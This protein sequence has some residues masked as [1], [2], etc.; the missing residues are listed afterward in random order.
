MYQLLKAGGRLDSEFFP[1]SIG[2]RSFNSLA[3]YSEFLRKRDVDTV[4]VFTNYDTRWKTNEHELLDEL[5]AADQCNAGQ[6]GAS[7]LARF[8]RFDVYTIQRAC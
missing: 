6:V 1:E 7:V 8:A 5:A 4:I 3:E 2:R